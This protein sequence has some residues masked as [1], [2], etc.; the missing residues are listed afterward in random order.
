MALHDDYFSEV[1][2]PRAGDTIN[3]DLYRHIGAV[4]IVVSRMP[5]TSDM[6]RFFLLDKT[7]NRNSFEFIQEH[8]YHG[9]KIY[10]ALFPIVQEGKWE[11]IVDPAYRTIIPD[12]PKMI[13]IA[14]V[15]GKLNI[16][17]W[18]GYL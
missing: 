15:G 9:R 7:F 18:A 14:V 8:I 6:Q 5:P 3:L 11:V 16:L 1:F 4:M 12:L 17:D 10:A 2:K 13:E